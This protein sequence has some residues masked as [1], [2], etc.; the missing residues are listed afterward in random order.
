MK[1]FL[2]VVILGCLLMLVTRRSSLSAST[3]ASC[4]ACPLPADGSK[5]YMSSA[6]CDMGT[7]PAN[8]KVATVDAVGAAA[9]NCISGYLK[10][11]AGTCDAV[12]SCTGRTVLSTATNTCTAC[13]APNTGYIYSDPTNGCATTMC[14]ANSTPNSAKTDCVCNGG[15]NVVGAGCVAPSCSGRTSLANSAAPVTTITPA[16]IT[17][18]SRNQGQ[19]CNTS[20]DC[21]GSLECIG[22]TCRMDV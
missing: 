8:S 17:P 7:C 10:N 15:Y 9:C 1:I 5:Y 12:K 6:G 4:Q 19:T 21:S 14:P 20:N 11:S 18:G 2:W 22:G 16:V 13:A 3:G